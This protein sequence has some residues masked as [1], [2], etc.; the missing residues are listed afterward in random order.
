MTIKPGLLTYRKSKSGLYPLYLRIAVDGISFREPLKILLPKAAWIESKGR[1]KP[2][3]K[4]MI[5][6]EIVA[7]YNRAID[8]SVLK[9]TKV[10]LDCRSRVV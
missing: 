2:Y 5:S 1:C 7:E 8:D 4:K 6:P 3:P 10:I 9:A